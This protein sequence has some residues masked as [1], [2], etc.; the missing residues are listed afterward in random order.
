MGEQTSASPPA[1]ATSAS[2]PRTTMPPLHLACM[3]GDLLTVL[4]CITSGGAAQVHRTI[5]MRNQQNATVSGITPLFLAAQRGHLKVCKL[6]VEN[7]AKPNQPSYIAG[8]TDLCTPA[9]VCPSDKH[10]LPQ[11]FAL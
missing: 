2:S 7:G 4:D 3:K 5:S 9:Q 8:S 6:L 1:L 11:S 10:S